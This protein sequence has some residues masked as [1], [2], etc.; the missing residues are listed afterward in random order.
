MFTNM[1]HIV[2]ARRKNHQNNE[3]RSG[4]TGGGHT[5]CR[6]ARTFFK[7]RSVIFMSVVGS[8]ALSHETSSL[9]LCMYVNIHVCK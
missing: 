3:T 6:I 4:G 7:S 5:Y 8:L 9:C 1:E 2:L